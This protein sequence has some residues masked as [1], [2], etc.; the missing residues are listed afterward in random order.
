M[1]STSGSTVFGK[2]TIS[3][4]HRGSRIAPYATTTEVEGASSEQP[5]GKLTSVSAIPIYG[6]KNHEE[7][8]W[9]DYQLGDK[10]MLACNYITFTF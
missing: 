10:G 5:T 4:E 2:G 8:R 3:N 6:D 9:E 1:V 7:L